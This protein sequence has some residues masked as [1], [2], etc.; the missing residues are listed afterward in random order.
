MPVVAVA[1]GATFDNSKTTRLEAPAT[2]LLGR[3]ENKDWRNVPG[4]FYGAGTDTCWSG[5]CYAPDHI[6]YEDDTYGEIVYR[7]PTNPAETFALLTGM[8][9]DP[10]SGFGGDGDAHWTLP[11]IREWWSDR[12][13]LT[14]WID[15]ALRGFT[16]DGN[17]EQ[18]AAQSLRDYESHLSNGLETYLVEYAFWVDN[19]R[20]AARNE[21]RPSLNR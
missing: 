20:P 14:D 5:R 3:W 8:W 21:T 1:E 15:K 4:P 2:F 16:S 13:R 19:G 17:P 6:T 18:D 7:Q 9:S 12:A 11:L 10:F